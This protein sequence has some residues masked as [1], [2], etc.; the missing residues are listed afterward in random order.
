MMKL[1]VTG[2][3]GF[4]G[5]DFIRYWLKTHPKDRIVNLDKLTYA[6]NLA[7][8][9]EVEDDPRYTLLV[10][11][12]ADRKLVDELMADVDVVVHYAAET[13]VDRSINGPAVFLQTNV[14]G[15]QVL[16]EAALNHK[17]KR[18]HHVSTD[19]VF[20]DLPLDSRE[21][22]AEDSNYRP[23]SPY[24]ASKAAADHLVRAYHRTFGLPVT[25]SNGS[26]NYGPYQFPEKFIARLITNALDGQ[27]LPVYGE[28]KNV[29]DWL[30]VRDHTRG[31]ER[32]L[33]EG[34]MG[35]TYCLGGQSER[36]NLDVAK[37]VLKLLGKP[38]EMIE[39]VADR[40]GHDLRY[41]ID[42][43]KIKNELKWEPEV[44]FEEGIEKTTRWYKDNQWWWRPLKE[45]AEALYEDWGGAG[46]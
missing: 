21:K 22:F 14:I 7:N 27:K 20:G 4:M 43:K 10:G 40:R 41:A 16:L 28:G 24:A 38:E 13:H 42:I 5:S 36:A 19:E 29:R 44:K 11:D 12:I 17:I 30:Y 23:S 37:T 45:K 46:A 9:R 32:V 34:R 1:L 33:L 3:A 25:I 35:E 8:L 26:N 15:T 18:F 31:V 6:A 39:F 2:G